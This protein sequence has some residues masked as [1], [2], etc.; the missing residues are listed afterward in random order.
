VA[1][2]IGNLGPAVA[3]YLVDTDEKEILRRIQ[4]PMSKNDWLLQ[5]TKDNKTFVTAAKVFRAY[6]SYYEKEANKHSFI[7]YNPRLGFGRIIQ[8]LKE[9]ASMTPQRSG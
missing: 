4:R 6:G 8:N 9:S 5:H 3:V 1:H 7:T 2:I